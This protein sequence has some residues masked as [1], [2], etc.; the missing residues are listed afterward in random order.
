MRWSFSTSRIFLQCPRKWYYYTIVASP[1]ARNP[2]RREAH[3]LKQLQTLYAWRGSL[4]DTVISKFVAP[5][6]GSSHFP[7]EDNIIR[8]AED[9][10]EKQLMFGKERRYRNRN[11]VKSNSDGAYCCFYDIEYNGQLDEFALEEAKKEI[12]ISLENLIRSD[13]IKE[14]EKSTRII[15]QRQLIFEFE[16]SIISCTPDLLAFYNNAPP[17]IVDWKVHTFANADSEL[18][19]TVYAWALSRIRQHKDFPEDS[20]VNLKDLTTFRLIEYQ[21]IRNE[22]REH[23]IT[24][25]DVA[26]AEDYIFA[27]CAQMNSLLD[28][29]GFNELNIESVPTTTFPEVCNKCV[30]KKLCWRNE[31]VQRNLFEVL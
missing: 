6:I 7:S 17:T 30:F 8:Y 2:I 1:T 12:V 18:Q 10:M 26:D 4:V 9:L 14:L 29:K 28:G 23:R 22:L 27:S 21:L 20:E 3:Q 15:T 31:P 19:L 13:L 11:E 16:G 24:P 25:N 5:R